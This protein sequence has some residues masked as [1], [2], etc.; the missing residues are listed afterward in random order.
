MKTENGSAAGRRI[1]EILAEVVGARDVLADP[2]LPL[3][4]SGMLDSL[5]TVTLMVELE[6]T[7]GLAISPAEFDREAWATPRLL[8][9][10]IEARL[11][12]AQV[13]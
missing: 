8:V 2:D 13:R 3:Y 6:K 9:G 10:D 5:A 11:D 4:A 7:F 12:R 1:L